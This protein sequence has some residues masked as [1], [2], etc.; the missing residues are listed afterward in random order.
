MGLGHSPRIVTDG[1]VLCLDAA[2]KRSYGG[3]GITWTDLKGGVAGTLNN[4]PVFNADNGGSL[5]FDGGDDSADWTLGMSAIDSQST[6]IT[7]SINI[8]TSDSVGTKVLFSYCKPSAN[9][10]YRMQF[11]SNSLTLTF[12]DVADYQTGIAQSS[13]ANGQWKQI[14]FSVDG[15]SAKCYIDSLEEASISVG[16]PSLTDVDQILLAKYALNNNLNVNCNISQVSLYNRALSADE[17]RQN[18]LATKE[19]YI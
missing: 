17:I 18:Y 19:R 9:N 7:M 4:G 2:N 8:K 13:L 10:G 11:Y 15:S 16:S 6:G 5:A 14:T 3:S 1:L 12:G